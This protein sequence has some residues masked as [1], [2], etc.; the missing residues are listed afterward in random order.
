MDEDRLLLSAALANPAEDTPRL[1]LADWYEEH[2]EHELAAALRGSR[3]MVAFLSELVRWDTS[4]SQ[5]LFT[6]ENNEHRES[7]PRLAASRLL[8]RY[9]DLFPVPPGARAEYQAD[10][11]QPRSFTDPQPPYQFLYLWQHG[12]RKLVAGVRELA[13]RNADEG[14]SRCVFK[15]VTD[16][17]H[18]EGLSCLVQELVLRGHKPSAFSGAAEHAELMRERDHPLA[19]LPLA[20]L[21]VEAALPVPWLNGVGL[22]GPERT[23]VPICSLEGV[24]APAVIDSQSPPP[25]S[26]L[27]AAVHVWATESNGLLEGRVFRLDRVLVTEVVGQLWFTRLPADS[28]VAALVSANWAITRASVG[29]A[30]ASLFGAAQ[31]GGAYGQRQWGA[32]SRLY[33]W[34]SIGALCGCDADADVPTIAAVAQQCEWFEFGGTEWFYQITPDLGLI[35]V[36]PDRLTV[37]LLAATDT[38]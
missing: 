12:R 24:D 17:E 35:C 23:P 11:P 1:M 4:P 38:D 20:R 8:V 30:L 25:E 18:F 7:F 13:S 37:A 2:D 19:W 32:Y 22:S 15:P 27:F 29:V 31:S 14:G 28:L 33:S 34:Q 10:A 26:P 21:P 3:E 6:F 5:P 16:A 9:R 36:R